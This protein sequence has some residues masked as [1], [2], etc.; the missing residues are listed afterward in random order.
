MSEPP[1]FRYR[2]RHL[3]GVSASQLRRAPWVSPTHGTYLHAAD[4]DDLRALCRA[5]ALALPGDAVFTHVTA[6]ALRDW[7]LP[8]LAIP[9]IARSGAD[10]PHLDRRG[11]YVR[12]CAIPQGQRVGIGGLRLATSERTI[13][14]LAE[15]L[16]LIDLVVAIDGALHRGDCDLASLRRAVVPRRR[17]VRVLRRAIELADGRSE[18]PWETILRLV[19]VLCG[20]TV[21]PQY[22]VTEDNGTFVARGDLRVGNSRRLHEYDGA[23]HRELNQQ[24]DDLRRDKALSR[25]YWERYGFAAPEIRADPGRIIRDAETALGLPHDPQRLQWWWYEYELSSLSPMGWAALKRRLSRF[26]RTDLPRP[27][28]SSGAR[29]PFPGV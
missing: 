19:H 26:D 14:E 12:R 27:R 4:C 13:V 17:G 25:I 6:A 16:S 3:F 8:S 2:D 11:V 1:A 28:A 23:V 15:D 18:S 20:V 7:W 22:V 21:T 5:I 9:L 24:R 10:A 29:S